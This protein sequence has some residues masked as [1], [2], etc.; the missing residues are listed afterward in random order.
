MVVPSRWQEPFGIVALEGIA[1]GCVL[2]GS[3]GGGLKDAIGPCGMTFPNG[4]V[5]HLT[6]VLANLLSSPDQLQQYRKKANEHLLR[7]H[8]T[9]VAKAYLQVFEDAIR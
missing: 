4:S 1:C 3:E 7:H 2:V 5:D 8:P 6:Q 9:E